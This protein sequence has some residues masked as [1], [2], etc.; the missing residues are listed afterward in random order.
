[1]L[2]NPSLILNRSNKM[3]NGSLMSLAA[4][5]D[6]V[7]LVPSRFS[8]INAT[9]AWFDANA[10][11]P[12]AFLPFDNNH[13]QPGDHNQSNPGSGPNDH[14]GS[15]HLAVYDFNSS[16]LFQ[17]TGSESAP[18]GNYSIVEQ[19]D[20]QGGT[21]LTALPMQFTNGQW[22]FSR[23]SLPTRSGFSLMWMLS[24]NPRTYIRSM[25]HRDIR[26]MI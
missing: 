2:M 22:Q 1:M 8:D 16:H 5:D 15:G 4:D 6:Y 10:S 26:S 12:V 9:K 11:A 3:D 20:G 7:N 19:D 24:C 17:L 18:E 21:Y 23:Y 25:N 13:S 14:N